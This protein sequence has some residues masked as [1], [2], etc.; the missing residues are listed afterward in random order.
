MARVIECL[1]SKLKALSSNLSIEL[2]KKKNL[3]FYP[4]P[5]S[6]PVA[7]SLIRVVFIVTFKEN[8]V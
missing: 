3:I 7:F 5:Q 4:F 2:K 8:H 6:L 1:P